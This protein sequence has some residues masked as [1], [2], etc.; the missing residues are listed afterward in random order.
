M[1][2][3]RFVEDD[4]I[5]E[6]DLGKGKTKTFLDFVSKKLEEHQQQNRVLK[7][8]G[9]FG[10]EQA[11]HTMKRMSEKIADFVIKKYLR[12]NGTFQKK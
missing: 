6:E 5:A 1:T 9:K 10:V 2:K 8:R 7:A 3:R 4:I 12:K 11:N